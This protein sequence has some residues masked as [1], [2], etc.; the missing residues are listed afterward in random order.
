MEQWKT[1]GAKQVSMSIDTRGKIQE[2]IGEND[3]VLDVGSA[4][5]LFTRADY[6][7]DIL[8]FEDRTT[9]KFWGP[10]K[11]Y[12][13]KETW[14][15]ADIHE[16]LPFEDNFFDFSMCTHTLEDIKDPIAV[17]KELMRVSK[18]GY[19]ECPSREAESVMGLKTP[20]LVGYGNHRWFV[21]IRGDEVTFTSKTPY[22]YTNHELRLAPG[23]TPATSFVGLF[24]KNK[25][26]VK[27]RVII[28]TTETLQDQAS[29][30]DKV[31]QGTHEMNDCHSGF[32]RL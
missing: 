23:W 1:Y 22:I 32:Y 17:C 7:V 20:G 27:E 2:S 16:P 5:C 9:N 30:I 18:S 14:V 25:F 3:L 11:E 15:K 8:D 6:I 29:F 12:F 4:K 21:D 19:I 13:S 28:G 31:L 26:D 24:W 10:K